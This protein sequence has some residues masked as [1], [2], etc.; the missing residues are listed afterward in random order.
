MVWHFTLARWHFNAI[1]FVY[2][3]QLN[4]SIQFAVIIL[5][6]TPCRRHNIVQSTGLRYLSK[7]SL[8]VYLSSLHYSMCR[9]HIY[10]FLFIRYMLFQQKHYYMFCSEYIQTTNLLNLSKML[11]IHLTWKLVKVK[12]KIRYKFLCLIGWFFLYYLP[13]SVNTMNAV[14]EI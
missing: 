6:V 9:T 12:E 8:A 1:S 13:V 7:P 3:M 4:R 2:I 10:H 14:K 5:Y 11:I